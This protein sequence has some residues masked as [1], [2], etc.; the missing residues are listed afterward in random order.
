VENYFAKEFSP[1]EPSFRKFYMAAMTSGVGAQ[2]AFYARMSL[3]SRETGNFNGSFIQ[4]GRGDWQSP[5]WP[6]NQNIPFKVMRSQIWLTKKLD[7]QQ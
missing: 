6:S 3:R 4:L 7:P 1:L 5:S 2:L